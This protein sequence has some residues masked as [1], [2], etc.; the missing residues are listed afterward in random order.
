MIIHGTLDQAVNIKNANLLKKWNSSADI[1]SLR[2]N[3]TFGIKHPWYSKDL[4]TEMKVV[5]EQ[6]ISF[7][8]HKI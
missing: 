7:L 4:S 5:V 6:T 8:Q 3:H 2:T 1:F